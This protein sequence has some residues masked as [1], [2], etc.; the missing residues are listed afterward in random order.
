MSGR[1]RKISYSNLKAC[2]CL[3]LLQLI[4]NSWTS[5]LLVLCDSLPRSE[6]EV[7]DPTSHCK[8]SARSE[9]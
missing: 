7:L 8:L 1:K 4:R 5:G 3:P 6:V 9:Q 2:K